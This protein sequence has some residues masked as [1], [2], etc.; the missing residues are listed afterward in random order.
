LGNAEEDK[1]Q[2]PRKRITDPLQLAALRRRV[3]GSPR[4]Q[5]LAARIQDGL[6]ASERHVLRVSG[7]KGIMGAEEVLPGMFPHAEFGHIPFWLNYPSSDD[8]R[9]TAQLWQTIA[10]QLPPTNLDPVTHA[11]M[12][13]APEVVLSVGP[14]GSIYGDG[15]Y[16]LLDPEGVPMF[17]EYIWHYFWEEFAE[18]GTDPAMIDL[19]DSSGGDVSI[20]L[21]GDWGTGNY[22][23][24]GPAQDVMT[25]I[26]K[27]SPDYII[28][29]GDVYYSG[30]ADEENANLL[31][32]WGGQTG[33]S[34]T[35]NSNHEMYD[36]GLGYFGTTLANPMF[37]A[38]K[39][40]SYFALRYGDTAHGGPWTIIALDSA[41][42][43]TSPLVMAGSICE[44]GSTRPGASAQLNFLSQLGTPPEKI[45]LVTHHNPISYDGSAIVDDGQ[46]N[47]LWKQ[48]ISA[49]GAPPAWYWGHVHNGI[50]YT[51]A[52]A[53]GSVRGRCVGHG[54][55][56]F[57]PAS[58]LAA[59]Q[60]P[61]PPQLKY[62]EWYANTPN[63]DPNTVPRVYN[64]FAILTLSETG[65]VTEVFYDQTGKVTFKSQY[66]LGKP[67]G[68]NSG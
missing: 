9:A 35:L 47:N 16:E 41:Y 44:P 39:G 66:Q 46:G 43:S 11:T 10:G 14:D 50:V 40:T 30:S 8:M 18:F 38:Q 59:A 56:P 32:G 25:Q 64:G 36:G 5:A 54:A 28:H 52:S 68:S 49:L 29:L 33:K 4:L 55:I 17:G 63:P 58:G 67:A 65:S 51:Q 62:V 13:A 15:T 57:G 3:K 61:V 45:I 6:V 42:W 26:Q 19:Q 60:N 22:S 1:K 37:G 7:S 48:V 20:A 2:N 34:F 53:A 21:V 27:L 24:A 23:P 31:Q 12:L